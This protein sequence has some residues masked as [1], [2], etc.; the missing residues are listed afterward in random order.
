MDIARQIQQ[1]LLPQDSLTVGGMRFAGR[2]VPAVAVG[3]DCFAY[4]PC[5]RDRI[6]SFVG[7][8]SGH[9]VG[10][11]LLM[12]IGEKPDYRLWRIANVHRRR[13]RAT[14]GARR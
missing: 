7:D 8:V 9:G 4:L 6:D 5:G 1:S 3:G 13:K 11:A 10:A 2:C 14:C 12:T